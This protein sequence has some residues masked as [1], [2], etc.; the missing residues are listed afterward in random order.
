M[1]YIGGVLA[2]VGVS[3]ARRKP[4]TLADEPQAPA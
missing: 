2:L 3:V 4:R 1:A